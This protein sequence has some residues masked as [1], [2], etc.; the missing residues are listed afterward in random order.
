MTQLKALIIGGGIGG[1][2]AA[3]GLRKRGIAARV[4]EQR[5]E[6]G[7]VGAG[8]SLWPNGL[9][10]LDAI[11]LGGQV[12]SKSVRDL[13]SAL[14]RADGRVIVA[15]NGAAL[16]QRLGDVSLVI[17][18]A[19]LLGL[20]RQEIPPEALVTGVSCV[21]FNADGSG[22]TAR[23]ANGVE[24]RGDVLLGADGLRSVVRAHLFGAAPPRYAGYTAWRAAVSFAHAQLLPGISIGHGSQFGQVPMADGQVYWFATENGPP[25]RKAPSAGWRAHLSER[26]G[27]WHAPIP[28]LL[29]ATP[30]SAILHNDIFDRPP[31]ASWG[32]GRVTLLGDAAHPM[33]PNLGQGANQALEDAEALTE[34]LAALASPSARPDPE[35]ALRQYEQLRTERANSVV[36]GSRRVGQVIQLEH[37]AACWVR[38]ALLGTRAATRLQ[39]RELERVT[40]V[41]RFDAHA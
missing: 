23:F 22:V 3:V 10:A 25:G 4:F 24:A 16:E 39:M 27:S 40:A 35:P 32:K 12:R 11:G 18:R 34:C 29:A 33:T 21:G 15:A 8:L 31:L 19:T 5:P 6:L 14:R 7:E 36:L 38:D 17:H 9:R 37:P 13:S 26:F 2:A 41:P 30:E 28:E 1:L 20:L